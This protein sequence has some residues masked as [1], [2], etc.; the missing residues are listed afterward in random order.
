MS[1]DNTPPAGTGTAARPPEAEPMC[2]QRWFDDFRI[3]ER[4]VL[5]SRTITD[6]LFAAFSL[7]SGDNHPSHYDVEYCRRAACPTCR[8]MASRSS[9]RPRRAR[10]CSRT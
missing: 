4:F 8:R 2:P 1:Q 7:A 9:S 3:G 6:A 5:P 10:A